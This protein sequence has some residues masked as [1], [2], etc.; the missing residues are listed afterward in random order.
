MASHA[1][2]LS[3]LPVPVRRGEQFEEFD[4]DTISL[5]APYHQSFSGQYLLLKEAA[6]C[7]TAVYPTVYHYEL[8][9]D[10]STAGVCPAVFVGACSPVHR[11]ISEILR[12]SL[13]DRRGIFDFTPISRGNVFVYGEISRDEIWA[14]LHGS[15]TAINPHNPLEQILSQVNELCNPQERP[16]DI[17]TAA[18]CESARQILAEAQKI[19]P[20]C[21]DA[22][23]VEA[24]EGDLLIHWDTPARS[25][26][27]ICPR[28]ARAPS[29]YTETLEG[30]RSTSSNLRGNASAQLL[31]ESLAWVL[32]PL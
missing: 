13:A 5:S 26:V 23:A 31:S 21:L 22:T 15:V 12:A 27:L 20:I 28:D 24:S 18:A 6:F 29:I 1:I 30:V 4:I 32:S 11:E 19:T 25:L 16:G 17:P 14:G 10:A 7:G 9:Q 3:I 8:V 2:P